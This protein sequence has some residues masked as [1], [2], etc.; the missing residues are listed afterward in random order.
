MGSKEQQCITCHS[1]HPDWPFLFLCLVP[2]NL[3]RMQNLTFVA[4]AYPEIIRVPKFKVGHM[5]Y[6]MP[7]L[8][9]FNREVPKLK[10]RS[11]DLVHAP[12]AQ[13]LTFCLVFLTLN[14]PAK[15]DVC[16]FILTG[17]N[18]GSQNSK[19]GHVT[20][21]TPLFGQIFSFSYNT[22]YPRSGCKIG[23]L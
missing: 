18:R 21:V 20:K 7:I 12:L 19:V 23:R 2:S 1:Q 11:H 10:S 4:S 17:D 15:F 3:I 14:P 5:T 8:A 13:F 16:S 6:F 22:P 9:H